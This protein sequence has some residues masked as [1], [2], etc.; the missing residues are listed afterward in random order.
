MKPIINIGPNV[1]VEQD[2]QILYGQQDGK[3]LWQ[4]CGVI[5]IKNDAVIT[6]IKHYPPAASSPYSEKEA[7][8]QFEIWQQLKYSNF[9]EE[10]E[11]AESH[12]DLKQWHIIE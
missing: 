10:D 9:I 12:D 8:T 6:E 7:Q 11:N 4:H 3:F 2:G 5:I 1:K